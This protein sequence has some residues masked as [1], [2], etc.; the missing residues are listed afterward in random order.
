[1]H[2]LSVGDVLFL[3]EHRAVGEDGGPSLHLIVRTNPQPPE[4]ETQRFQEIWRVDCFRKEPHEHLFKPDGEHIRNL[5]PEYAER[6]IE[7]CVRLLQVLRTLVASVGYPELVEN[8][9]QPSDQHLATI[10]QWMYEH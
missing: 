7:W 10:K 5:D 1:M 4:Q 9:V 6:P 8:L 3:V 2:V